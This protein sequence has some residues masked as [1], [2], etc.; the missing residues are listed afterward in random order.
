[1][2]WVIF[3][4]LGLIVNQPGC[5]KGAELA[6]DDM[7]ESKEPTPPKKA[8]STQRG[9]TILRWAGRGQG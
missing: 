7:C 1:M 6:D 3:M 9:T 4:I 8:R 5:C 2:I